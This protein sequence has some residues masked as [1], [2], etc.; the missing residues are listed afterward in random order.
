MLATHP[1]T[2]WP[3]RVKLFTPQA[4]K[5]WAAACKNASPLPPGF[6]YCVELEG[7]DGKRDDVGSGRVGPID[8]TDRTS[9]M[10]EAAPL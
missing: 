2:S 7:V 10:V 1:Y 9:F 5:Y 3:L 4:V 6:T 8:V